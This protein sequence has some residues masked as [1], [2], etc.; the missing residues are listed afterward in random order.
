MRP[1][2]LWNLAGEQRAYQLCLG[3]RLSEADAGSCRRQTYDVRSARPWRWLDGQGETY[4]FEQRLQFLCTEI[5][6]RSH[7]EPIQRHSREAGR[8]GQLGLRQAASNSRPADRIADFLKTHR[9]SQMLNIFNFIE[10]AY[11]RQT[12]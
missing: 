1:L 6:K 4:V 11:C 5:R 3:K 10:T 7:L 12:L 9:F 2:P 8:S